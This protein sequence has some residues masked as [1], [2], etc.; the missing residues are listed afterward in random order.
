MLLVAHRTPRTPDACAAFAAAGA[1]CFEVD[2]QLRDDRVVASHFLPFLRVRGWFEHDGRRFRWRGGPPFD[3]D[4]DDVLARVPDD[5]LILVD[6]KE[7]DPRRRARLVDALAERLPQRDRFRVSTDDADDLA[8]YRAA[9]FRTWRTLKTPADLS[10][11]CD[12]DLADDAVSVRHSLLTAGTV[13]ALHRMS[14]PV[15]AWTVNDAGRARDLRDL[16]VDAITTDRLL[17]FAPL[18]GAPRE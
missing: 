15:V 3:P 11:A 5:R 6:P 12:G 16:G 10:A 4:L 8:R 1:W 18:V 14:R 13:A 17:E 7:T 2:V 9:G